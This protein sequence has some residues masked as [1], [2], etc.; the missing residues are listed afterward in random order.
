MSLVFFLSPFS[1]Y[2]NANYVE[3]FSKQNKK[4]KKLSF[5]DIITPSYFNKHLI[6][7]FEQREKSQRNILTY[8]RAIETRGKNII[9]A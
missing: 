8:L 3:L 7:R 4:K 6:A 2:V 1:L 9:V 5:F